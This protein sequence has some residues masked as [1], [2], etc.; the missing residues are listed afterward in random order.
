MQMP[1]MAKVVFMA[2]L[3]NEAPVAVKPHPWVNSST[4]PRNC[5]PNN[6]LLNMYIHEI[7]QFGG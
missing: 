6:I 4:R 3:M 1:L 5:P 7:A 2:A